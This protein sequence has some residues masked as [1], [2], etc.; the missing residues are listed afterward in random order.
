MLKDRERVSQRLRRLHLEIRSGQPGARLRPSH[1]I[2]RQLAALE[3]S[4]R[5]SAREQEERLQ[6]S[7][8]VRFP[9]ALP[10]TARR[11]EIVRAV[12]RHPVVIIAGETG[13]GKSTQ[14]PKMCL[15]SGRGTAGKIGC[16]QPR[17]IAAI[18]IAFR[19]AEE[20]GEPLGRSV[21]YKIRFQDRTPRQAYI[22]IMT[23]GML[24][25]ETQPDRRLH[26]YDTLII[27]EAHERSVN[28][29]FLLGIIQ[30]LL[31]VRPELKVIITSATMDTEKFSRAFGGAPVIQVSG[32]TYPVEVEY[33]PAEYFGPAADPADYVDL[34]VRAVEELKASKARGDVL[35]FMPT[36]QDILETCERIEG[37][38]YPGTSIL[39]LYARLPASQQGR[40]YSVK[41]SKIVVATNVAETSLT[42]PGIRY[43]IDTGLARLSQ[44]QPGSRINSLPISPISRASA[45]QRKGRCG[46]VQEGLCIRLYSEEDYEARPA[47]T[48]PEILRSNLAEILLRMIAL[49]LGHP[50][51]FPFVDK[52]QPRAIKDGFETL[53]ELGAIVGQGREYELTDLGRQMAVMPLDPRISRMLLEA[54]RGDCLP[55]VAVIAAALS[56][57]DPRERPPDKAGLADQ[58]QAIFAH[59]ESDFL[60][61]LNLW[62]RFHAPEEAPDTPSGKKRFCHVHFLSYSRMREW[63]FVHDQILAILQEQK[64]P[65]GRRRKKEIPAAL[66]AAIHKA[67]L[68]GFLSN[69]AARKEKNFYQAAKGREV[70]IFPGS[71]LFNKSRPWIV[72]AEMV[73]TSRLY[74]RTAARI[75]PAWVEDVAS[76]LCRYTYSEPRWDKD[77]G[78]VRAKEKVAL[79]GLE[80][81]AGRDVAYG[82]QNPGEAH[83]IFIRQALVE[84]QVKNPPAFLQH[85]LTLQ[86]RI[87]QVE[88]KLRRRDILVQ[89]EAIA[90]FYAHRLSGVHDLAGLERR[91][92]Q[93]GGDEFLRLDE[94]DLLA[95]FP[96]GEALSRYPDELAIGGRTFELSYRFAPGEAADGATL[97]VPF[98]DIAHVPAEEL[99]WAVPG[100]FREKIAALLKGLPK[101]SRKQLMPLS[102][103]AD[104]IVR[105]IKRGDESFFKTLAR[106]VKKRFQ[107]N[108]PEAEWA[109]AE[110]PTHLRMR[111]AVIDGQ[112]R[113]VAA[114]R[115]L[116]LLRRERAVPFK[117]E[118]S[119][120][121]KK[122]RAE[123]ERGGL[124]SWDFGPLPE[125][126]L[127]DPFL[128]A[129][130]G[131]EPGEKGVNLRLFRTKEEALASHVKGVAALLETRF[132]RDVE[133]LKRYLAV[134]EEY[135]KPALHF[136][137]R[138]AVE[139]G[140]LEN[141]R[142][143]IFQKNLR[144][145]DELEACA[146][147]LLRALFEK[148]H[149]LRE[150]T[151]AILVQHEQTSKAIQEIEKSSASGRGLSPLTSELRSSLEA[152]LPPNFLEVSSLERLVH[153]PRFLKAIEI[154][155]SRARVD[156]EKD[157]RKAEQVRPFADAGE[158][159]RGEIGRSASLEKKKA[160]QEFGRMLEEFKVSLFAPE[161]RTAI[162]ISAKR[163]AL[164]LREIEAMD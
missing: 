45:D 66:Y 56:I 69:I 111:V 26:E 101:N 115:S 1:W 123:W 81:I 70:M 73:R 158:R 143:E 118:D 87:R 161:L 131:L 142:R 163:L 21:G 151:F 138:A 4:L 52:P 147:T 25:A 3:G 110:I 144:S 42:I 50:A 54:A 77:R 103:T 32:R 16:T 53:L 114:S 63:V 149:L 83:R 157:R 7:P 65:L 93:A 112:G 109:R 104:I 154:R 46:R 57:R 13:C 84:G 90:D 119:P 152:L 162:P 116:E 14:L 55:E 64:I 47:F 12:E 61:L 126:I 49:R 35:I 105:E 44:Y 132:A 117:P 150:T 59:P 160:A 67:V 23:D 40:V 80:L 82:P 37:K 134:F 106:F 155:A 15:E 29:D 96:D 100:Y 135:E 130:P 68:S 39:P 34:A 28:I 43:V 11:R 2:V 30:T 10:I 20:L 18:T 24:L 129:Y 98:P 136:G 133:F 122:A 36:E 164:K 145:R 8:A 120:G 92:G 88:E 41:G 113:E 89:E 125:S 17:R 108:I 128:A 38:N 31:A 85:N 141:I 102:E 51:D 99:D 6:R 60:T 62:D 78:E 75:D 79:F 107:V 127:V 58:V 95:S 94:K 71:T 97:R 76:H 74:A 146:E 156:P 9:P 19:I 27:D 91:L 148:S 33:M 86:N 72:A 48:P 22:K 140:M 159:L 124:T 121:W 137:G 139:K 5:Q 153:L